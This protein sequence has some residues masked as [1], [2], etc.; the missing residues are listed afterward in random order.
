MYTRI[1]WIT[2]FL[3]NIVTC[4]IYSIYLWYKMTKEMNDMASK[5]GEAP[6]TDYIVAILLGCVTCG[7]YTIVWMFKFFGLMGTLS[8]KYGAGITPEGSFVKI[9]MSIIP[10]YS[11]YWLADSYNKLAEKAEA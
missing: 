5:V 9:I 7:I 2:W 1:N 4:G 8:D 3:L 11:F 10:I 6:I